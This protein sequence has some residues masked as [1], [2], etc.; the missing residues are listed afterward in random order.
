MEG[1]ILLTVAE[2]DKPFLL[3]IAQKIRKLGFNIYATEGTS[4]FLT[5]YK[6]DNTPIKKLQEGRPNIADAIKNGDINL[7][8]N[9]PIGRSS[10]YDD[11]YIRIM[12]IQHKIPYITSLTAAEASVEGIGAALKA[13]VFPKALQDYY[14]ERS[15]GQ[16]TE[17]REQR[18]EENLTSGI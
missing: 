5:G 10:K 17:D 7:V 6:I 12:A 13:K 18:A 9:T 2:K 11:S 15:R 3:P 8:I 16:K 1:N 14:K 4:R